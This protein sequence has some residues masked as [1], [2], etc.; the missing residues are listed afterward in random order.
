MTGSANEFSDIELELIGVEPKEFEI[1]LLDAGAKFAVCDTKAVKGTLQICEPPPV[2]YSLDF[3][4]APVTIVLYE[5]H[6]ARQ[7]AHSRGGIR[8]DRAQRSNVEWCFA[9]KTDNS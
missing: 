2:K 9:E 8:H 5:H 6:T 4:G 7:A 3:A 1:Y